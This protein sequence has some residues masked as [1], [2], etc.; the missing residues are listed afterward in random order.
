M[1]RYL[2]LSFVSFVFCLHPSLGGQEGGSVVILGGGIGGM[3][4]ALYLARAGLHPLV[5]EGDM[6]GGLLTESFSVQNWP[7]EM[8][9]GGAELTERVRAQA[10]AQGAVFISAE[11]LR[12]DFSVRPFEITVRFLDSQKEE[13]KIQADACII[14]MG[15]R[16]HFLG[17]PGEKTY[18]GKGISNCAICDGTL[19]RDQIVGVVGGGDAAVLEAQYLAKIA[20]EVHLFVRKDRLRATDR[21]RIAS[22]KNCSNV[23]FHYNTEIGRIE[24]KDDHLETVF[25]KTGGGDLHPMRLNGLFLAIGS[26]PNS[27]IFRN[28]LQLDAQGYIAVSK[29]QETSVKGVYAIGD[30]ADPVYKQAVCAASDGAKAALEAQQF[31]AQKTSLPRKPLPLPK[32]TEQNLSGSSVIEISSP[33]EWKKALQSCEGAS[34][35]VEFYAPWCKPC[36]QI[37]PLIEQEAKQASKN[38]KFFKVNVD[39]AGDLVRLYRISSMPTAVLF[40]ASGQ[41]VERQVGVEP[42][43]DLLKRIAA[44]D[45]S[46]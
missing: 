25:L 14:A 18:W 29:T 9:I 17:V 8:D 10:E 33:E 39:A 1:I 21:Q 11:A 42:I 30:I 7:G 31:V 44:G 46:L 3:T 16:P 27:A 40:D 19:Y 32:G 35:F 45:S 28:H 22:L 4:S 38:I 5:I 41:E 37:L 20:K 23:I 15:T 6:P 36:K 43:G 34:I 12:V 13:K 24:G 26:Q 2:I